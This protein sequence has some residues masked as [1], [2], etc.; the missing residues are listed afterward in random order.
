MTG[1]IVAALVMFGPDDSPEGKAL[2]Y[3]AIEVPRWSSE[4][5][6]FSC[7]NNGDGARALYLAIKLVATSQVRRPSTPTDG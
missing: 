6:C 3:L 4:H 7:H 2:A 1:L 5:K